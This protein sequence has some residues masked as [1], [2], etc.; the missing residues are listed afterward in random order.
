MEGW[1]FLAVGFASA[2]GNVDR[3][4]IQDRADLK[5]YALGVL[6]LASLLLTQV[7]FTHPAVVA[8]GQAT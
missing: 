5:Q 1:R 8:A 3:H 4:N 7:R 2:L 6:G